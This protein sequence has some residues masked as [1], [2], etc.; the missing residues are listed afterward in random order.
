MRLEELHRFLAKRGFKVDGIEEQDA[1]F[2]VLLKEVARAEALFRDIGDLTPVTFMLSTPSP[3]YQ[4][5]WRRF[6][7]RNK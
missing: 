4:R 3:W 7:G 5:I 6:F 2:L 1:G